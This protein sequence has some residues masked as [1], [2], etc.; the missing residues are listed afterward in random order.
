MAEI[1]DSTKDYLESEPYFDG[2]YKDKL[3]EVLYRSRKN[4]HFPDNMLEF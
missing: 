3:M 1:K 2:I 4:C